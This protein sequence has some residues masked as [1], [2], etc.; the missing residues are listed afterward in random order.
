M[1]HFLTLK[2]AEDEEQLNQLLS[3]QELLEDGETEE[4]KQSLKS[5]SLTNEA[6]LV[7]MISNLQTKI[8]RTKQKIVA[9]NS[10][11]ENVVE[12]QKSKI[13]SSFQPKDQQDFDE[14]ISGVRKRRY[15]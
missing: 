3:V 13:K 12:D 2:L 8:E 5:F 4:F 9:A 1:I 15:F 11:E 6:E 14:W 7:K 10:Q